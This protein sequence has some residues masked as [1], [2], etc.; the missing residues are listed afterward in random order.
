MATARKTAAKA[1]RAR[2][3]KS[4]VTRKRAAPVGDPD[5]RSTVGLLGFLQK[6]EVDLLF[7]QQP[8]L[9][10][11]GEDPLDMW[12]RFDAARAHLAA[13][14][15]GQ[16]AVVP[17]SALTTAIRQRPSY[18][19]HYERF[20]DYRFASVPIASLLTPQW[21]ADMDYIDE[22]GRT[23]PDRASQDEQ[24][25]FAFSEG[26]I[27][28][29]IVSGGVV[30]FSSPRR[31]LYADPVPRVQ[32]TADGEFIVYVR[33]ASRPNYIQVAEIGQ[34]LLLT[35]GVHKV[36]A[37]HRAGFTHCYCV[38]RR[39]HD[40]QEAGLDPRGLS[41]LRSPMFDGPRPAAVVDFLNP[42]TAAPLSLRA[43]NQVMQVAI[44][45]GLLTVP[46]L[47]R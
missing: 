14:P 28:E 10:A 45:T 8:F 25:Q 35:N 32:R 24:L 47:P 18:V 44:Q 29:P 31:D 22:I 43:M 26:K 36:C 15:R 37:L 30:L 11:T 17:D 38:V 20:A 12:R 23:L 41:L 40:V 21:Y 4:T 3:A 5:R 42:A 13:I 39:A 1:T 9:T 34:Q 19:E 33:A 7:K 27:S 16:I 46:A 6:V 2:A